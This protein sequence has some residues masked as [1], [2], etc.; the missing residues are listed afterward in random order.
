MTACAT[1]DPLRVVPPELTEPITEPAIP[2]AEDGTAGLKG[3]V[4]DLLEWGDLAWS[5]LATIRE[6]YGQ[7]ETD[8]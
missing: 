8:N 3:Y 2:A 5:R 4:L 7:L 6:H 1:A